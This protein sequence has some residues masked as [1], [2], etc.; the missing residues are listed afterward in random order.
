MSGFRRLRSQLHHCQ[1]ALG[2]RSPYLIDTL[3]PPIL[4]I[5]QKVILRLNEHGDVI[6]ETRT[7]LKQLVFGC[8]SF[9]LALFRTVF[10]TPG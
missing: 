4:S 3:L 2:P 10:G 1:G 8:L 6:I 5:L 7:M 9:I